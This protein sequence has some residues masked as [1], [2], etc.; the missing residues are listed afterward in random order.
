[1]SQPAPIKRFS[2]AYVILLNNGRTNEAA[3]MAWASWRAYLQRVALVGLVQQGPSMAD[4]QGV[5]CVCREGRRNLESALEKLCAK[6]L[7]SGPAR[8][9][10]AARDLQVRPAKGEVVSTATS[11]C[12]DRR[13]GLIHGS[14]T[15]LPRLAAAGEWLIRDAFVQNEVTSAVEVPQAFSRET[16]TSARLRAVLRFLRPSR[17]GGLTPSTVDTWFTSHGT[18]VAARA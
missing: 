9:G 16:A 10:K 4:A 3:V 6:P 5:L 7:S 8:A 14:S 15:V 17:V 2:E 11:S 12:K 13:N 1:M 18:D